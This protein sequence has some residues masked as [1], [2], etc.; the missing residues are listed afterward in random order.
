MNHRLFRTLA[1]ATSL[2]FLAGCQSVESRIQE[3]PEVFYKLDRAI[4]DKILQGI[5][6]IGFSEDMVYLA[7]GKPDQQ[8]ETLTE[9]GRTTTWIYNTYY[10]RYDGTQMV[11]YYRRVYYDPHLRSYRIYYRPAF[12]DTYRDEVEERIRITFKDGHATVIEQA[13]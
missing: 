5:I 13:K 11:G 8:R 2:G 6:D 10:N 3:K 4:Q 9:N 12:A 7:L 1:L